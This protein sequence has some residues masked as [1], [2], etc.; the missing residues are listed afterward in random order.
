MI[1]WMEVIS[2]PTITA[3]NNFVLWLNASSAPAFNFSNEPARKGIN[4]MSKALVGLMIIT[5]PN[6]M[7][8][9]NKYLNFNSVKY[10]CIECM[11]MLIKQKE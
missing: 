10:W 6:A 2:N 8:E 3:K 4:K 11:N 1:G 7:D 9:R 5:N